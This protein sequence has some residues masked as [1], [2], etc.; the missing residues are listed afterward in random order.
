MCNCNAPG[1]VGYGFTELFG[2]QTNG[3]AGEWEWLDSIKISWV[4]GSNTL[5]FSLAIYSCPKRGE[6]KGMTKGRREC[7]GNMNSPLYIIFFARLSENARGVWEPLQKN[8][9]ILNSL[10][11]GKWRIKT[12]SW[13][14]NK[15]AMKIRKGLL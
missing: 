15:R 11:K 5:F 2:P 4:V 12:G 9:E 10:H 13:E 7:T 14:N 8:I 6:G 3:S 1:S